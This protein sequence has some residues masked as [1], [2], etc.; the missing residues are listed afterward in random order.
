[1]MWLRYSHECHLHFQMY[2]EDQNAI[3]QES[4]CPV[5]SKD[6]TSRRSWIASRRVSVVK[7]RIDV[8]TCDEHMLVWSFPPCINH[9]I[10]EYYVW[11]YFKKSIWFLKGAKSANVLIICMRLTTERDVKI[12]SWCGFV[13]TYDHLITKFRRVCSRNDFLILMLDFDHHDSFT[14]RVHYAAT[15][16][17][18]L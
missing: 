9:D 1:M 5:G 8:D 16:K 13:L 14:D 11:W 17:A 6:K 12:V 4:M 18:Y 10:I 15:L 3:V 7:K 2:R